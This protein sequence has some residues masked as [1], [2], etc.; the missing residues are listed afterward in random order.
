MAGRPRSGAPAG[1]AAAETTLAI[2]ADPK[3]IDHAAIVRA[4]ANGEVLP[5]EALE[6]VALI[7]ALRVAVESLNPARMHANPTRQKSVHGV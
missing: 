2:A 4:I 5:A 3:R 6:V 1:R 7:E